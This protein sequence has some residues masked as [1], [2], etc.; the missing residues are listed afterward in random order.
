MSSK[1]QVAEAI[2]NVG[3]KIRDLKAAKATKAELDLFIAELL[4]LKERLVVNTIKYL[5]K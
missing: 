5:G 3:S 4:V 2:V 1:E